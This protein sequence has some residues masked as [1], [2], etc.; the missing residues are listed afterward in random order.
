MVYTLHVY[1]FSTQLVF[2]HVDSRTRILDI[3]IPPATSFYLDDQDRST[4]LLVNHTYKKIMSSSNLTE[5]I[6]YIDCVSRRNLATQPSPE[7]HQSPET[8]AMDVPDRSSANQT[9]VIQQLTKYVSSKKQP[10]IYKMSRMLHGFILTRKFIL[11]PWMC[12]SLRTFRDTFIAFSR[13]RGN[14][15]T[16]PND[17]VIYTMLKLIYPN[18]TIHDGTVR[19]IGL[20]SPFPEFLVSSFFNHP[21]ITYGPSEII[22]FKDVKRFFDKYVSLHREKYVSPGYVNLRS[23][24][25][26]NVAL[27]LEDD[28]VVGMSLHNTHNFVQPH[29]PDVYRG[30]EMTDTY[31]EQFEYLIECIESFIKDSMH[32]NIYVRAESIRE[33]VQHTCYTIFTGYMC[34]KKFTG[35]LPSEEELQKLL[36]YMYPKVKC[37]SLA[38]YL[39]VYDNNT[40][41]SEDSYCRT[42]D[43]YPD[44]EIAAIKQQITSCMEH[45]TYI[46]FDDNASDCEFY[47][48][49]FYMGYVCGAGV[50]HLV[51]SD[52]VWNTVFEEVWRCRH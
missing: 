8:V 45:A 19:G 3:L 44:D 11:S 42:I 10:Q 40:R 20:F 33:L 47:V 43:Q 5:S 39:K 9:K 51:P 48:H 50:P 2:F 32:D 6:F 12:M 15:T 52:E 38:Y 23:E 14:R 13:V 1:F 49:N 34:G 4:I 30:L 16:F 7:K 46:S 26:N 36:E 24:I 37:D 29:I 17:S 28:V 35:I 21:S 22:P 27:H 25:L 18:I 41:R 31:H